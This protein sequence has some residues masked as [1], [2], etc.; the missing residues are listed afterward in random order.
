MPHNN[1]Q[2]IAPRFPGKA[3]GYIANDGA[4]IGGQQVVGDWRWDGNKWIDIS[5]EPFSADD[6]SNV[7]NRGTAIVSGGGDSDRALVLR[8]EA[9]NPVTFVDGE[10][11][12][13]LTGVGS[14]VLSQNLVPEYFNLS[15]EVGD[16]AIIKGCTDR[17]AL[18]LSLIHI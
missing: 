10:P 1:Q 13:D 5:P 15:R 16:P 12:Y 18:N 14:T 11:I 6:A 2:H 8:G 17:K 7:E 9:L 4:N 3:K